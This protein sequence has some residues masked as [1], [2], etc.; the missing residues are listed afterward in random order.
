V[1]EYHIRLPL[2]DE[3]VERLRAGDYVYLTGAV[4]TARDAAHKRMVA[5]KGEPLPVTSAVR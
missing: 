1:A 5:G 3:D 4:L 2:S